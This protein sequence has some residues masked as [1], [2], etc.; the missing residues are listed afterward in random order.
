MTKELLLK[1]FKLVTF[2]KNSMVTKKSLWIIGIAC[3]LR[4]IIFSLIWN[5]N[6]DTRIKL[7]LLAKKFKFFEI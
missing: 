1:Y 6:H 4:L 2:S 5:L 3:F 7:L